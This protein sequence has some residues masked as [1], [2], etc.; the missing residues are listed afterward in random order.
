MYGRDHF[1]HQTFADHVDSRIYSRPG[2]SRRVHHRPRTVRPVHTR[3]SATQVPGKPRPSSGRSTIVRRTVRSCRDTWDPAVGRSVPAADSR[4]Y[5]LRDR[6]RSRKNLPRIRDS[7][8]NSRRR[9]KGSQPA[10]SAGPAPHRRGVPRPWHFPGRGAAPAPPDTRF[11]RAPR[12][13]AHS[14]RSRDRPPAT[15]PGG[16]G[17][18]S[19]FP[20]GNRPTCRPAE[21]FARMSYVRVCLPP[22][23]ERAPGIG[24]NGIQHGRDSAW[25]GF[26]PVEIQPGRVA[27]RGPE[28]DV[29]RFPGPRSAWRRVVPG[30]IRAES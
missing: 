29:R 6:P 30:G 25:P 14:P 8:R 20:A 9:T 19:C 28:P 7:A 11:Q 5:S 12:I 23:I 4:R 1:I 27:V 15:H 24:P 26:S 10:A 13:R 2:P 22:D 18:Q 3:R 17:R 16:T 21:R